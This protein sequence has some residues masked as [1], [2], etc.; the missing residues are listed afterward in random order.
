MTKQLPD[1]ECQLVY[2]ESTWALPRGKG[3]G[4]SAPTLR[5]PNK[6]D[7]MPMRPVKEDKN[8]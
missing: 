1:Y 8:H 6:F 4:G 3:T 5:S 2:Q 7:Q